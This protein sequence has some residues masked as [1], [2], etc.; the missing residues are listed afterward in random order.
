MEK[1]TLLET[2]K[3]TSYMDG[4]QDILL[5]PNKGYQR[6]LN[7]YLVLVIYY[8]TISN[9]TLTFRQKKNNTLT[10]FCNELNGYLEKFGVSI[11]YF[12]LIMHLSSETVQLGDSKA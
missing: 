11:L 12:A 6:Q 8:F 3:D 7:N 9:N 10:L 1:E 2:T 5:N 4:R